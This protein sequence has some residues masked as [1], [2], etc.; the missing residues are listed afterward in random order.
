[1]SS[2]EYGTGV[3]VGD[4]GKLLRRI[5]ASGIGGKN[6]SLVLERDISS[7]FLALSNLDGAITLPTLPTLLFFS[8]K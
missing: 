5:T 3:G 6:S 8:L 7:S 1:M 4:I 2:C